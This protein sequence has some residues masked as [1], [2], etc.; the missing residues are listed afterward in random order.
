MIEKLTSD[1]SE[2]ATQFS[3][4]L[5]FKNSQSEELNSK[6]NIHIPIVK[7]PIRGDVWNVYVSNINSLEHVHVQNIENYEYTQSISKE[8][9]KHDSTLTKLPKVGDLI[10]AH[11]LYGVWYRATVERITELGLYVTFIDFGISQA[12]VTEFKDLPKELNSVTPMAFRCCLRN[13]SKENEKQ[14]S[15]LDL[16]DAIRK[17]FNCYQITTTFLSNNEPYLVTLSHNENDVL[18]IVYNL[19]WNGIVPGISDDPINCAKI[20][21]LNKIFP[22]SRTTVVN[23]GPVLSMN[24]FYVETELSYQIGKC[25]R[26][27]IENQTKWIP[28]LHPKEGQIVIAKN[29]NDLKLYR[30]R[31]IMKYNDCEKYK[32]FLIDCMTFEYCSEIFKPSDYLRKAPPVKIHCSL[33]ISK[34]YCNNILESMNL[35]FINEIAKCI[36]ESKVMHVKKIDNPCVIDLEIG[37]LNLFQVIEPC[38]VSVINYSSMNYFSVRLN[39]FEAKQI[40]YVLNTTKI[41]PTVSNPEVFKLYV[42]K[43]RSQY[44]RVKYLGENELGLRVKLVDE[45]VCQKIFVDE[46]YELPK[47]IINMKTTDLS[48]SL[49]LN[50]LSYSNKLFVDICKNGKTTFKMVVIND[51]GM[52]AIIVKLFL[53]CNDITSMICNQPS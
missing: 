9:D 30:A 6:N 11:D 2:V 52:N 35:A 49:G 33:D 23:I 5:S 7:K 46:L 32:C 36:D 29:T 15:V 48:C 43:I 19:V 47:S 38:E 39:S 45:F 3:T 53:D 42:A 22:N 31:V 20:K 13:V 41:L 27:E 1:M 24:H 34:N 50:K 16:Y 21:M 44:K 14:L 40:S 37:N 10:A 28:V 12:L 25:I 26:T 8:L 18:D 17:F 51:D 4:L